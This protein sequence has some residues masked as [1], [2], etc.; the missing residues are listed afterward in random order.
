M[1]DSLI[2]A[3]M[4]ARERSHAPYSNFR[5][6]AAVRTREGKVFTGS[7]V[8]SS[9]Y[10]LTLC[11]ERLA[12]CI[13]IHEGE[14]DITEIAVVADT[15]GAP[16]PCGACRQFMYDFAPEATVFMENLSGATR[17]AGVGELIPWGF[18]P[19]DLLERKP[20]PPVGED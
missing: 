1:R 17:E 13:A 4:E 20:A 10:G 3:A 12:I 8:E 7:N 16:G 5:V 2:E 15:A 9:S 11:A 18:G 14:T 6:G 19:S